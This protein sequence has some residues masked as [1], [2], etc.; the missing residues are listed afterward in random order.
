ML[1]S[2]QEKCVML[3]PEVL[4]GRPSC[5]K[6][7]DGGSFMGWQP[8][9]GKGPLRATCEPPTIDTIRA[10]V[11]SGS[12][13]VDFLSL[14]WQRRLQPLKHSCQK[15]GL[16]SGSGPQPCRTPVLFLHPISTGQGQAS[17]SR[18]RLRPESRAVHRPTRLNPATGRLRTQNRVSSMAN[19][20]PTCSRAVEL[21][22][23]FAVRHLLLF[24]RPSSAS[25]VRNARALQNGTDRFP[26]TPWRARRQY[27]CPA[28]RCATLLSRC[29]RLD[30]TWQSPDHFVPAS[31]SALQPRRKIAAALVLFP[32]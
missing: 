21:S 12:R 27:N 24:D 28:P 29:R 19:R 9:S 5:H 22:R 30:P 20:P 3:R 11:G 18:T 8:A 1:P 25:R 6:L 17:R 16:R 31:R 32:V 15:A 4:A 2:T 26:T 23:R 7:T 10:A 14:F 13:R